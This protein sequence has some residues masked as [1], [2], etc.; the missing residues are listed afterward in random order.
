MAKFIKGS[1][2]VVP[3]PFSD[4]SQAK[5]RPALVITDLRNDDLILCQITSQQIRDDYSIALS[6]KDF[7]QGSLKYAL[8]LRLRKSYLCTFISKPLI[9]HWYN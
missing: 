8:C 1:I 3:F 7:S 9:N 5:K 2:V 6:D 4:L